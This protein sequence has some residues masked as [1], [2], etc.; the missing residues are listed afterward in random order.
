MRSQG[1]VKMPKRGPLVVGQMSASLKACSKCGKHI[2][3][4]VNPSYRWNPV[5]PDGSYHDCVRRES[6]NP[7]DFTTVEDIDRQI[8]ALRKRKRKLLR[9]SRAKEAAA[10]KITP[11]AI[12][13]T[14]PADKKPKVELCPCLPW[15]PCTCGRNPPAE[16]SESPNH[17]PI[18]PALVKPRYRAIRASQGHS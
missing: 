15:E 9:E 1:K 12:D 3:F 2:R 16:T 14:I 8:R 10:Q 7:K 5:N 17:Y 13:S 4:M 11:A 6:P 18:L